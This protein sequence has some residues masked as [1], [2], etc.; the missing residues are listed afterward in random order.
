MKSI[1]TSK[2]NQKTFEYEHIGKKICEKQNGC[3]E[4]QVT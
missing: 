1:G 2:K 4:I 3:L